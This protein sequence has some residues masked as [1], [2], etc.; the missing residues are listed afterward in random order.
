MDAQPLEHLGD[1]DRR[2]GLVHVRANINLLVIY[3]VA[4]V[5]LVLSE[6]ITKTNG[7][8]RQ[9]KAANCHNEEAKPLICKLDR[10]FL[11]W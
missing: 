9:R 5:L 4:S 1:G 8:K 2:E 6:K 7:Q 11:I 3:Q 10:I